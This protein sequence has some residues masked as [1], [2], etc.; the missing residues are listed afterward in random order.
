MGRLLDLS[1]FLQDHMWKD[2][3]YGYRQLTEKELENFPGMRY[4]LQSCTF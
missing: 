4:V 2:T 1:C 3:V